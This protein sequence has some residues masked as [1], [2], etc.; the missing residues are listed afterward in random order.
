MRRPPMCVCV[1]LHQAD[2]INCLT[3]ATDPLPPEAELVSIHAFNQSAAKAFSG[4]LLFLFVARLELEEEKEKEEK[5]QCRKPPLCMSPH[6]M[7]VW[8]DGY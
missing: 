3:M 7:K 2:A 8:R 5:H 6:V 4:V 1:A